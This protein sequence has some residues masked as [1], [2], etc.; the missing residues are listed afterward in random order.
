[1][2]SAPARCRHFHPRRPRRRLG[3]GRQPW[4]P[5]TAGSHFTTNPCLLCGGSPVLSATT[6]CGS[7]KLESLDFAEEFRLVLKTSSANFAPD[8]RILPSLDRNPAFLRWTE[9][10]GPT[11][12]RLATCSGKIHAATERLNGRS[13]LGDDQ[14]KGQ[15][16][17][18]LSRDERA[19]LA[20]NHRQP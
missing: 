6:R 3:R 16:S 18:P 12:R 17:R 4:G 20:R 11:A 7:R 2:I 8:S 14:M 15:R 10:S 1:M 13:W 5:M 9:F 19:V